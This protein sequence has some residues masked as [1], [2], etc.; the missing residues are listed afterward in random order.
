MGSLVLLAPHTRRPDLSPCDA[1]ACPV[2]PQSVETFP[3]YRSYFWQIASLASLAAVA[4]HVAVTSVDLDLRRDLGLATISILAVSG[5]MAL[6]YVGAIFGG[7]LAAAVFLT[8]LAK[9]HRRWAI[10]VLATAIAAFVQVVAV[11]LLQA[12][13]W[14]V[15]LDHSWIEERPIAVVVAVPVALVVGAALNNLVP[16]A[17][18][19][20]VWRR[21][22]RSERTFVVLLTGVLGAGIAVVLA[23]DAFKPIMV[24]RYLFAVPVLVCAIMAAMAAKFDRDRPLRILLALW[25]AAVVSTQFLLHGAKPQWEEGARSVAQIVEACP[26]TRIYAASGWALGPAAETRAAL[27]EDP[28]FRRAYEELASKHD[29]E[30][31]FLGQNERTRVTLGRCPVLVWYEHTPNNAEDDPRAAVAAAGLTGIEDAQLSAIRNPTGFI[32]RADR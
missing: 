1:T 10:L 8:A 27:R 17:A 4:R 6:H 19:W 31:R 23:I 2:P 14:A 24:D 7:L 22:T 16:L 5:S 9:R 28:V 32:V 3:N 18:L 21:W 26:T 30:V 20:P 12:R 25:A 29:Y 13:N 15:D 11:A